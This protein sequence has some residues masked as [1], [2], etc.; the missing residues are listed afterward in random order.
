MWPT[1][2]TPESPFYCPINRICSNEPHPRFCLPCS[3]L[4]KNGDNHPNPRST[5]LPSESL[6][7][8][9]PLLLSFLHFCKAKSNAWQDRVLCLSSC[10]T[11][12]MCCTATR[13]LAIGFQEIMHHLSGKKYASMAL[14][15]SPLRLL[16][17]SSPG[18]TGLTVKFLGWWDSLWKARPDLAKLKCSPFNDKACPYTCMQNSYCW[19]WSQIGI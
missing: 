17:T 19:Q 18:F 12:M 13:S 15:N 6:H 3:S 10:L 7:L 4:I 1:Q 9:Q 2:R 11:L 5:P 8:A 14:V 16:Q